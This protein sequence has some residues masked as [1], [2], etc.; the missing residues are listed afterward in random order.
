MKLNLEAIR[1]VEQE[2]GLVSLFT[3]RTEK[4]YAYIKI[5]RSMMYLV[6]YLPVDNLTGGTQMM[7]FIKVEHLSELNRDRRRAGE[8]KTI[9]GFKGRP[10]AIC[11]NC[12]HRADCGP[13]VACQ[14]RED[15]IKDRE[16]RGVLGQDDRFWKNGN[17]RK[18]LVLCQSSRYI[19]THGTKKGECQ[20]EVCSFYN[21]EKCALNLYKD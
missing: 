14:K 5:K 11:K 6:E 4:Q 2:K 18:C 21:N 1:K 13:N 8:P 20:K 10:L 15:F 7:P 12:P 19:L 3:L 9:R 17:P 16:R